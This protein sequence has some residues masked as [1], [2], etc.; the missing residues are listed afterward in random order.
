MYLWPLNLCY[1][2]QVLGYTYSG[3]NL[4]FHSILMFVCVSQQIGVQF[5]PVP[6]ANDT[7]ASISQEMVIAVSSIMI[8]RVVFSFNFM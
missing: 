6:V 7:Y 8:Q 1:S 3:A 2:F 5:K 4:R